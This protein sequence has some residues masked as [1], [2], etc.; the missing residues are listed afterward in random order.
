M[1]NH[2]IPMRKEEKTYG[3]PSD[4]YEG[5]WGNHAKTIRFLW[6]KVRQLVENYQ[7]PMEKKENPW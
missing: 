4:S 2:Q 7:V 5:T 6:E 3:K 1:V